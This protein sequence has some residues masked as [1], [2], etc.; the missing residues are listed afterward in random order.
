M[1]FLKTIWPLLVSGLTL[2]AATLMCTDSGTSL[3]KY[4][5]V[6]YFMRQL[7]FLLTLIGIPLM[8]VITLLQFRRNKHSTLTL[9][10]SLLIFGVSNLLACGSSFTLLINP[11]SRIEELSA[12]NHFYRLD[13]VF[14]PGIGGDHTS[15]L[16]LWECDKIGWLCQVIDS[17]PFYD[18][19]QSTIRLDTNNTTL[20]WVV[21]NKIVYKRNDP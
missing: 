1:R 5:T 13:S 12:K 4:Q 19:L 9:I 10:L 11:I 15:L 16:I 21:D 17:E 7:T 2:V 3:E 6:F 18:G 8:L 14:S 20:L